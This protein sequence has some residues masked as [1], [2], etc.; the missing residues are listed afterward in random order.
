MGGTKLGHAITKSLVEGMAG[1]IRVESKVG[2]G[3]N[4]IISFPKV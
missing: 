2:H 3:S 4:F 1:A